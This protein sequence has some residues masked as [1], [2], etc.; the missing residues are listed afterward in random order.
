M[1]HFYKDIHGFMTDN[2][3]TYF[4]NII[5][6]MPDDAQ[7]V[8]VGSWQGKSITYCVVESINKGKKINFHCVD[9][10]QGSQEHQEFDVVKN[11]QL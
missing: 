8:E 11:N 7:W 2:H 4:S 6:M 1:Q 5:T 9:T 3:L 10:W